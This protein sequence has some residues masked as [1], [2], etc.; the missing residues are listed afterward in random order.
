M[1]SVVI[2]FADNLFASWFQHDGVLILSCVAALDVTEWRV[3][4]HDPRVTQVLESHQILGL[5]QSEQR[6][7]SVCVHV[8]IVLCCSLLALFKVLPA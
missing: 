7:D 3:G 2:S 5:S 6:R 4:L 8:Q 1:H